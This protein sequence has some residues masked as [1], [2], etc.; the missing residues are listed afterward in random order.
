MHGDPLREVG[1]P[2]VLRGFDFDHLGLLWLSDLVWRKDRWVANL[3]QVKESAFRCTLAAAKKGAGKNDPNLRLRLKQG[4]R[5]L[6]TR[7]IKSVCVWFEDAET[8]EHV[9]KHL[10]K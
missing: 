9:T 5:I 6:L 3:D 10:P 8:R 1:C 7:A 4:Y 2:H